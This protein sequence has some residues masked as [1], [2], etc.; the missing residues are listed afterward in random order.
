MQSIPGDK[1]G[2]LI[3]TFNRRIFF[4]FSLRSALDHT[5]PGTE[6]IAVDNGSSDG[7]AECGRR[8]E[9]HLGDLRQANARGNGSPAGR[10]KE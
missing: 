4:E 5:Y 9:H 8:D 2:V 1:A 10:R 3:P 7:T 6:I